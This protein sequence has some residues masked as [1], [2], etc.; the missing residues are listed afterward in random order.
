[1]A[2]ILKAG[3]GKGEIVFPQEIFPVES[4]IGVHDN[5]C[6]RVM[7]FQ[8]GDARM[9]IA[10]LE[11][12][13]VPPK[14]ID[15][16]RDI[17]AD[18]TG[19]PREQIW[20]H[21]THA[22]ATMHLPGPK[23]PAEKRPP[24]TERDIEQQG[25]F[26]DALKAAVTKAAEQAAESFGEARIG[27]GAGRCEVNMNRDVETPYGWWTGHNPEGTSNKKMTILRVE[28]MDGAP[29]GFLISYGIKPCAIDNAGME[30]KDRQISSDVCGV[31]SRMMEERFGAPAL[32][33]VSAAGD[34]VPREQAW[35]EEATKEGS[36]A[37]D[38]GVAK[39]LEISERL[40]S[41]MGQDAI[42]IAEQIACTETEA[43]IRHRTLSFLWTKKAGKRRSPG[44]PVKEYPADGEC[45]VE[46]EI[47]TLGDAAFVAEKPE[48]NCQTELELIE[49]SP[50][51]NTCLICMVNGEMKYMP[52]RLA[53]EHNTFECQSSMLQPGAAEKF[54]EEVAACLQQMR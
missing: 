43:Q 41:V 9:A 48:V 1:M 44:A 37:R 25:M 42:G 10:A 11:M 5:P 14:G 29:K 54:V 27:W 40:G 51:A 17:I 47:L 4:F 36:V 6:A 39:G 38:F 49:K 3:F 52:D 19:T 21:I 34:Q 32:F 24:L 26:Y 15:M 50:F 23:G 7:A 8:S 46:A 2:D 16:C 33:C 31:C 12:V 53:Y 20:I 35:F 30:T 18:R 13:N 22:I 28:G 45:T